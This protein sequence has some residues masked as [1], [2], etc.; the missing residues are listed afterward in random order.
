MKLRFVI[1]RTVPVI[2]VLSLVLLSGCI[3]QLQQLYA[4]PSATVGEEF[5]VACDASLSG[6]AGGSLGVLV[7]LPSSIEFR[8]A[9]L[10][11]SGGTY[12]VK[13]NTAIEKTFGREPG[14]SVVA[15]TGSID[16][17]PV[18]SGSVRL[19][20]Y[21]T[22]KEKG[23]YP[24][25]FIFGIPSS[26]DNRVNWRSLAP[27]GV[28][29][30]TSIND[31][32]N[33]AYL[34]N[35]A[36]APSEPNG[37]F[38]LELSGDRQYVVF[39]DTGLMKFTMSEDLSI[40]MWMKSTDRGCVLLSTRTDDYTTYY[41]FEI[42]LDHMG[43]LYASSSDG[44]KIFTA[45][46]KSL[47]SDGRW[48]HIAASYSTA[49]GFMRILTD[50]AV[51]DSIPVFTMDSTGLR[52]PLH[53]GCRP[54]RMHFYAGLIDELRIWNVSRGE[55]EV[56][57]YQNAVLSGFE[58]GLYGLFGFEQGTQG[59]ME[60]A[61]IQNPMNIVAYNKPKLVMSTAPLL[62]EVISFSAYLDE[63]QEKTVTLTWESF[64][65]NAVKYY[66]VEKRTESGKYS[67]FQKVAPDPAKGN[68]QVYRYSDVYTSDNVYFYRLRRLNTDGSIYYSDVYPI[69]AETF[70]NFV[71]ED[72]KPNPF[73]TGTEI[74]FTLTEAAFVTL[75]VYDIMGKEVEQLVSERKPAGTYVVPFNGADKP[76]GMYF[77]KLKTNTGSQTKK[78][79]LSK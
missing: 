68:H 24:L 27:E 22:G 9:A 12:A 38:A 76:A 11:T 17:S 40:E 5:C 46:S 71:L 20:L 37:T 35:V 63:Q 30:F 69:G 75:T 14:C 8:R 79:Y 62:A 65:D 19:L 45:F 10:I 41:P 2:L 49:T 13:R 28:Y 15:L 73:V 53:L 34:R 18:E 21:F 26:D 52:F 1:G 44:N 67:V 4:P 78:M 66:E 42:G 74:T 16:N 29:R 70:Y 36:I 59:Q 47:V 43:R 61:N 25:K 50:A 57:F 31:T 60:N 58:E 64:D 51:Q 33:T 55:E 39:P 54:T 56:A 23:L 48:R 6:A 3:F 77:Y 72:N 32:A 7:Q